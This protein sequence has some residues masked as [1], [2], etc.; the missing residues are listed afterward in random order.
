MLQTN[1]QVS[2]SCGITR[3]P[4]SAA[5]ASRCV[6]S[7]RGRFHD[8]IPKGA[9]R[10]AESTPSTPLV[11]AAQAILHFAAR[12]SAKWQCPPGIRRAFFGPAASVC[13][14]SRIPRPQETT[15]HPSA[16]FSSD[17]SRSA[18]P[19]LDRRSGAPPHIRPR[20]RSPSSSL[21][22]I[23]PVDL[24]PPSPRA[25]GFQSRPV[26]QALLPVFFSSLFSAPSVSLRSDLFSFS[27]YSVLFLSD[28][29]V[30]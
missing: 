12:P 14:A 15:A 1:V 5:V 13:R 26:A 6:P 29:C 17:T 27:V 21:A 19:S 28:L 3:F 2:Q 7:P 8:R 18:A 16:P 30:K 22:E 25:G 4:V 10:H 11:T 20:A 23:L 9:G 24:P